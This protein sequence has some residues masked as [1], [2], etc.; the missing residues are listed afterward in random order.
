MKGKLKKFKGFL[1]EEKGEV[2]IKQIAFTVAIIVLI[3]FV[4]DMLQGGLLRTWIDEIWEK[5]I[6]LIDKFAA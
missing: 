2:G 3:G 5:L 6:G 1:S 4:I